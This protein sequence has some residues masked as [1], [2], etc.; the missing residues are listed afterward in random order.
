MATF[1]STYNKVNSPDYTVNPFTNGDL[2]LVVTQN[3]LN[4]FGRAV[5][6]RNIRVQKNNIKAT[7]L[8]FKQQVITT[9]TA[10]LNLYW[11]LVS[12][13]QDLKAK[14]QEVATAQQL[15]QNNQEQVR[16]GTLAEIEITRAQS[17]LFAARQ[18]LVISETNRLQQE[19][20]LKNALSRSGVATSE[21][22]DVH[23]IPVDTFTIPPEDEKRPVND[24]VADAL[25]NRVEVLQ[26]NIN[27]ES[28]KLDL[29]GIKN[30]LKPTL[31]VFA[32]LTNNGLSGLG[33]VP[34]FSGGY[35]TLLAEIFRRD[36][37]NY[38]A[39]LSMNIPLRNRAAQS[40]YATSLIGIRQDELNLQKQINQVHVD[41]QNAVIG[42]QQARVRYD[43]AVE[44]RK[45]S[46]QTFDADKKKYELGAGTP[47]QVVQDQRDLAGAQS[48]EA[49]AMANYSHAQIAFDEALGRTLE[50]NHVSMDEAISG[51][52][53]TVSTIPQG[54]N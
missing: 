45:L 9:V 49:Q 23:V 5:N 46:Q 6:G 3:L 25:K 30:S 17:Q 54:V 40:D 14:Q 37:P 16:I 26:A 48:S 29:I 4:G 18:D 35:G 39:G 38:S 31:Q 32:E 1:A 44:A 7:D 41:V 2:D 52:V 42:L 20:V 12:F 34:G 11:D 19:T 33:N 22:A 24:L 8:Q 43:A 50:V 27:L 21:L 15:L 13:D 53:N 10:A 28:K 51:R 36:Y 47:Y